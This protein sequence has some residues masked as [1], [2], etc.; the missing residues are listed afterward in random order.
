MM[1]TLELF[2]YG[3]SPTW[4]LR[5]STLGRN[6]PS[7]AGIALPYQIHGQ[8]ALDPSGFSPTLGGH[9]H[10]SA[11]SS[12]GVFAAKTL[13][14][15][16]R[17]S[18]RV[19]ERACAH[20]IERE[21]DRERERKMMYREDSHWQVEGAIAFLKQRSGRWAL[22]RGGMS[23]ARQVRTW[24]SLSLTHIH[25][26]ALSHTL[27]RTHTLSLFHTHTLPHYLS[28]SLSYTHAHTRTHTHT[29]THTHTLSLS[30]SG[31][32]CAR[33]APGCARECHGG[34]CVSV[35]RGSEPAFVLWFA[36]AIPLACLAPS[37]NS[38]TRT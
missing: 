14:G 6:R 11:G 1:D 5:V 24:L 18:E 33:C 22:R 2:R 34:E 38:C 3:Q 19:S 13:L 12:L 15:R 28:R 20:E 37:S 8:G 21:R 29:H 17:E 7:P 36:P 32:R 16:S 4:R 25:Y 27:A 30:L 23:K 10:L 26:L 35:E 31:A 9:W